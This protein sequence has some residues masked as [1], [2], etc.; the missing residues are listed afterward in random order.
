MNVFEL[1]GTIAIKNRD[2]NAA[3]ESTATKAERTGKRIN[4]AFAKIGTA[5]V[6][7]GKAIGKTA[8]AI[9]T[10]Y[11]ATIEK[12]RD[13][14]TA[15][16][17]L[18]T[19]FVS[20]GHSAETA[21]KTYKAL[22][23]VLGEAD[24]ATEAANHLAVLC[25][26]EE[27]LN[28]WT[29]ICTGVFAT[30][31]DS[32]PIEGLTEAANETAK[33]G[34]VTGTLADA[35]NWAGIS[36]EDFNKKLKACRTEEERQKMIM[37]ELY[38]VYKDSSDQYKEN[39]KDIM[40][41]NEAND[42]LT[43][44]MSRLGAVGEPILTGMKNWIA[45]MINASV[46]HLETLITKFGEIDSVWNDVIWPL[47]QSTFKVA[48]GVDVPEWSAIESSVTTWWTE[49]AKPGMEKTFKAT[50]GI[51]PPKW[52]EVPAAIS[53]WWTETAK[54]GMERKFKAAFGIDPPKWSEIPAAISSWWTETA[55]PKIEETTKA[56]MS[57][58]PPDLV[59][60]ASSFSVDWGK[61]V[62]P[63]LL[64][65]LTGNYLSIVPVIGAAL[66]GTIA[67]NWDTY[68]KPTLDGF[69]NQELGIQLPD[70]AQLRADIVTNLKNLVTPDMEAA[71]ETI[72]GGLVKA[73]GTGTEAV[74]TVLSGAKEF[75][76]W[77]VN[78]KE[79]VK[80]FFSTLAGEALDDTTGTVSFLQL[81]MD[82]IK[83]LAALGTESVTGALQWILTHGEATAAILE[84]MA[85]G[86][87]TAAIAAHPY[88]AAIV[89][90][91]AA[92][93]L[94]KERNADG[95]AYNHFFDQ[96]SDEDLAKLQKWVEAA[97]ATQ[98]AEAA[99][100][101]AL[102]RGVDDQ[103]LTDAWIG[104]QK[105]RDAAFEEAN[106]IDGLI[107]AYN[108]WRT[109][110]A[111]NTGGNIYLDVPV[112]VEEG[113]ES[114]IQSALSSMGLSA[115]V[116][117]YPDYSAL[118]NVYSILGG[119]ATRSRPERPVSSNA[120]GLD[121]VPRD[122]YLARVHKGEAIL[123]SAQASEW[124][125]GGSERIESLLAQ[126]VGIM[127]AGQNIVLDSGVLVG[128]LAPGMDAR[129]GAIM[130]RKRRGN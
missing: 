23:A 51:D 31:G 48:F 49:T 94:M 30:F 99:V 12:T 96:Y 81:M 5:S 41:A 40:K 73:F 61:L 120:S 25:K 19:A 105:R 104:A 47:V 64:G 60:F 67:G 72:G 97:R 53:T 38:W 24:Q 86:F 125:G 14:R 45:N 71:F 90:A 52:S 43:R 13:Y 107:A 124:R 59:A 8:L 101:D 33:V 22:Q 17:K 85:V 69:L 56:L 109:G 76:E 21:M 82:S 128:Q 117:L 114:E 3:L 106:A 27:D 36:E 66:A 46:P 119:G 103:T 115:N 91:A 9:G 55:K 18:D 68:I 77:C 44:A 35:L 123:N 111:E 102:D 74:T 42:N 50:F 7:I 11:V 127:S 65:L 28:K 88:A 129:L 100:Q 121:Y 113:S 1:F 62:A 122:G 78:N 70:W 116:K 89:A 75:G 10:A 58:T 54:P 93:G 84:T 20:N 79:T 26:S 110:Q 118:N 37:N 92:L 112:R 95:D 34:Q 2:A 6:K 87:A 57:I 16:A 4:E 108:A 15:M 83:G 63:T 98:E 126:L 32:L 29:D 130:N 39:A 80:G